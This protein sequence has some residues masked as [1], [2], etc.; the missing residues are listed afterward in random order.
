VK[1]GGIVRAIPNKVE[2]RIQEAHGWQ[3]SGSSLL[4]DQRGKARPQ[5]RRSTSP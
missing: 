3:V 2:G 5:R 4:I 1:R